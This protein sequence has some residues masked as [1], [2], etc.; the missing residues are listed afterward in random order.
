MQIILDVV[1]VNLYYVSHQGDKPT[2]K[3]VFSMKQKVMKIHTSYGATVVTPARFA[4]ANRV[5]RLKRE[6]KANKSCGFRRWGV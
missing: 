3:R 5:D 2:T 1:I 4:M 6:L